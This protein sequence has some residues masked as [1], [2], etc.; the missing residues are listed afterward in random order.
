[1]CRAIRRWTIQIRVKYNTKHVEHRLLDTLTMYDINKCFFLLA[2]NN[3]HTAFIPLL[4]FFKKKKKNFIQSVVHSVNKNWDN[5]FF[6]STVETIWTI[7][8]GKVI[9]GVPQVFTH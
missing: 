2:L 3:C 4:F 9:Q 6:P 1:M 8:E 5:N 7:V